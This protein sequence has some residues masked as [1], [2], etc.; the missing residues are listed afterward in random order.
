MK[1]T[2]AILAALMLAGCASTSTG[3][4]AGANPLIY[5]MALRQALYRTIGTDQEKVTAA[6]NVVKSVRED[7][8]DVETLDALGELIREEVG[9][10]ELAPVDAA[11]VDDLLALARQRVEPYMTSDGRFAD[12]GR[13]ALVELLTAVES[14]LANLAA[15]GSR[16]PRG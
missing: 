2:V 11:L 3:P 15:R 4:A 12:D 9:Y 16:R 5:Q 14:D 1:Y 13:A 7:G 6:L 10:D 8:R